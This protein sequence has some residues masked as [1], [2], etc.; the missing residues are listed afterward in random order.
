M[1]FAHDLLRQAY[2]LANKE[3]KNPSQA[4]LRRAVSTGYYALFHLLVD[5]AVGKWF[6]PHQRSALART[7]EHR[8]MKV[9]CDEFV[10]NF[11]KAGSPPA[12][13]QLM[14]VAETFVLLQQQ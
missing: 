5:D 11:Y 4:S 12:G 6:V 9:V 1:P 14:S 7:F 8:T 13:A 2:H 3:R 10:K